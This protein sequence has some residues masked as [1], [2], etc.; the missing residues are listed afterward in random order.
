MRAGYQVVQLGQ[1]T[2]VAQ[3]VCVEVTFVQIWT[4]AAPLP[5]TVHNLTSCS[6]HGQLVLPV[7]SL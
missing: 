3:V 5:G 2:Q 1:A 4:P 7:L 6:M